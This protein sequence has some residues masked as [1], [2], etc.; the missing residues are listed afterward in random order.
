V[1]GGDDAG[2]VVFVLVHQ[3]QELEHHAGAAQGRGVCPSGESFLRGGNG[4]VDVSHIGQ[5][6][7]ACDGAGGGVEHGLCARAGAVGNGAVDVMRNVSELGHGVS[8]SIEKIRQCRQAS[9]W[10]QVQKLEL[11]VHYGEQSMDE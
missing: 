7:V 5:A 1:L 8:L 3:L 4:G 9:S 6:H 10:Q 2:Q 11:I